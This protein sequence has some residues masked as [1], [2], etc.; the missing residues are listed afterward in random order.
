MVPIG[1]RNDGAFGDGGIDV[2]PILQGGIGVKLQIGLHHFEG[3]LRV[4]N[5]DFITGSDDITGD[6]DLPIVYFDMSLG[7]NLPGLGPGKSETHLKNH[8]V[9]PAFEQ[10]E[11]GFPGI[12]GLPLGLFEAG[13]ELPFENAIVSF[14]FLFFA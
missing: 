3:F 5:G 8:I 2:Q 4:F 14:D 1:Q 13:P 10:A 7:D 6:I 9:E 12:S 11:Q